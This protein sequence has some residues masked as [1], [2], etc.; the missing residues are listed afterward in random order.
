M[1]II[2]AAGRRIDAS[3]ASSPRFPLANQTIVAQQI[4]ATLDR[5]KATTVVASAA[6]GADLLALWVARE[7]GVR[8]RII[9]PYRSEWFIEDSVLDRPG[10]WEQLYHEL[11]DEASAAGD[12]LVLDEAR[13]SD[14][15]YRA[16]SDAIAKETLRLAEQ[17]NPANPIAA[18]TCV[19]IWDGASRGPE[20][21]TA[22]LRERMLRMGA[23]VED[24]PTL[25]P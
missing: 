17:E 3:D 5:L 24:V 12:L 20:D 21:L 4:R 8:R 15:A 22:H 14:Q 16:A 9:L 25:H 13:G 11:C 7:L 19:I 23:Q 2:A 6:C 10:E 1:V 18:T